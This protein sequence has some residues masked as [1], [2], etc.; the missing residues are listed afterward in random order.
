MTNFQNFPEGVSILRMI[1]QQCLCCFYYHPEVWLSFSSFEKLHSKDLESA[2]IVLQKAKEVIP[3]CNLL[4]ISYAEI[5]EE[6]S[7]IS[8]TRKTLQDLFETEK[9]AFTFTL[10]QR[11]LMRHF[12]I[13][14]ARILFSSTHSLRTS[15][16][17][18]ALE[19]LR[20][21]LLFLFRD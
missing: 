16:P 6:M 2:R 17:E 14:T 20:H 18:L 10:F 9:T 11:F 8:E 19:V 1:F 7:N 15:N 12:G 5:N 3:A 4:Q 21:F 13:A